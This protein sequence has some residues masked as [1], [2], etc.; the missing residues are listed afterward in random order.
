MINGKENQ[1]C[2]ICNN[3]FIRGSRPRRF[4]LSCSAKRCYT[5]VKNDPK[6]CLSCR[7]TFTPLNKLEKFCGDK[8]KAANKIKQTNSKWVKEKKVKKGNSN[9]GLVF[10][11]GER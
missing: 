5:P 6:N 8:C 11:L 1:V 9:F 4:C 3:L 2:E 10:K 7:Q